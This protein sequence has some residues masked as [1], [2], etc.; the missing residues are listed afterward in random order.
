MASRAQNTAPAFQRNAFLPGILV[1]AVL[2]LAPV[3]LKTDWSAIVL[4]VTTIGALIIGWFGVQAKQWWWGIIFLA[5]AVL[6]NPV[7]PFGFEGTLWTIAQFVA[8]VAFIVA[9][10]VI[11]SPSV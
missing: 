3:I 8:A 11:K 4:Y 7:Y 6:W 1:A 9:G 2:F 10:V 5:V